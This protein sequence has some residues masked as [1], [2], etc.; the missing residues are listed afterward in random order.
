MHPEREPAPDETHRLLNPHQQC[1]GGHGTAAIA[2]GAHLDSQTTCDNCGKPLSPTSDEVVYR[3]FERGPF[4]SFCSARCH[5]AF[6]ERLTR[7]AASVPS[8]I[9]IQAM[10]SKS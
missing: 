1:V 6:S 5:I 4:N 3:R 2:R 10:K 7:L 9:S 8:R